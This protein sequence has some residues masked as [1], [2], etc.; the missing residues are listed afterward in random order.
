ML[1][2]MNIRYFRPNGN[3]PDVKVRK[4]Y[5]TQTHLQMKK[6]DLTYR[7][8]LMAKVITYSGKKLEIILKQHRFFQWKLMTQMFGERVH[9]NVMSMN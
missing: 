7:V 6:A 3:G 5:K 8:K 2:L 9:M 1:T 4:F